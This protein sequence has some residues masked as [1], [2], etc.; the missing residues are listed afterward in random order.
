M[1]STAIAPIS[2]RVFSLHLAASLVRFREW[3]VVDRPP[4]AVALPPPDSAPQYCIET[5]AYQ[6]GAEINMVMVLRDDTTG[7][8]VWSESFRLGLDNW[9]E[10]QQRI[11]RRIAT[12]LNVQLSAERLMRLAGEP[13]VS[14]DI[15]DRWLRGQN[16]MAKFDPESWQRAVTIFRDAIRENPA[17]SPCYSSLVQMNNVEHFVH[18]GF[19][20]DLGKARAT[21]ELAKTAVQLDPVDSRAHLCCGWSHVMALREAEA[22]PHMELACEL[23]DNDPWTLLSC[24]HYCAF[25]GS[26]EQARLR[27]DQSLALSRAPSHLE[28]GYHSI[29]RFLCGDYAGALE[30]CDRAHGVIQDPAG[31]A[32]GGAVPARGAGHGA[33]RGPAFPQ[34]NTFVLGRIVRPDRRGHHALAAAGP[35]DQRKRRDGKP[36]ATACAA[37]GFLSRVSSSCPVSWMFQAQML[38]V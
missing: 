34:R 25:C 36:C 4:A 7:I 20:R 9:F 35:S 15:H 33:G 31:M 30:A 14:L 18:P 27:A 10:A 23:N 19:F 3:S 28:W 5:T 21:L 26:I 8:Y 32:G 17:F 6:A 13:D 37:Q 24:A 29:I 22:A 2:C 38:I 1:A 16:L 11:I 12:S